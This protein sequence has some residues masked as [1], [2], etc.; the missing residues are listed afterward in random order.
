MTSAHDPLKD[1]MADRSLRLGHLLWHLARE[2]WNFLPPAAQQQ[3]VAIAP[4]WWP[5]P[6]PAFDHSGLIRDNGAGLDFLA[7]HRGMLQTATAILQKHGLPPIC[8]WSAPPAANDPSVPVP[9]GPNL[10]PSR[11]R[12]KD[13]E[14]W[15]DYVARAETLLA[16][17]SIGTLRLTELGAEIEFGIH[18]AMH[19]RFGDYA[20]PGLRPGFAVI[21]P[22]WDAPE[23]DSLLDPYSAHV[24][25]LFWKIH[26]WI[27]GL[28]G[29]W[30]AA[31][32]LTAEFCGVWH[33]PMTHHPHGGH[34]VP[35]AESL[36][37]M[38]AS[39]HVFMQPWTAG[40]PFDGFYYGV[41]REKT[42]RDVGLA[43]HDPRHLPPVDPAESRRHLPGSPGHAP[44][45]TKKD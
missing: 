28:I 42:E 27:D 15:S 29:R 13:D 4:E 36:P 19:I 9:R 30:E 10:P 34:V 32:G 14:V 44:R 12:A 33:G 21:G 31:T 38:E 24:H 41:V 11:L 17:K 16:P 40:A 3:L 25:P 35:S 8:P 18:A 26:G 22:E 5:V 45:P 6:R 1:H 39:L 2:A 43:P 20:V 37:K 23:Y 7:M